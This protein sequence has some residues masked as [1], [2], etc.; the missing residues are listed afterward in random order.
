MRD[1]PWADYDA[2][3]QAISYV[4]WRKATFEDMLKTELKD[5]KE[6]LSVLSFDDTKPNTARLLVSI[7]K[8]RPREYRDLTLRLMA[9]MSS[10][11]EF[12]DIEKCHDESSKQE[13]LDKAEKAVSHLQHVYQPYKE[14]MSKEV[15]IHDKAEKEKERR[16]KE[17]QFAEALSALKTEFQILSRYE[18]SHQDR[19]LKF[20]QWLT[21][22]LNLFGLNPRGPYNWTS[23][24]IDGAFEFNTD[25]YILEAK[26]LRGP[27]ARKEADIFKSKLERKNK[28]TL[29]LFISVN[30]FTS[31]FKDEYKERS[32]FITIDGSDLMAVLD[33]R[34]SLTEL[35]AAKKRHVSETG[36][37]YYPATECIAE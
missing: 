27:V 19:G 4:V 29:G 33:G 6:I 21:N 35:L 9:D 7:L 25:S 22:L 20:E 28:N 17:K 34:I 1:I 18:G 12:H 30:G 15:A 32:D 8:D 14:E 24:Q 26:W 10:F 37:C 16:E 3:C 13:M 5:H 23:D 31:D 36:D 2:L 11:T